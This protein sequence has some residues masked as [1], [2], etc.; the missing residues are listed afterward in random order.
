MMMMMKVNH[1]DFWS[2]QV[3]WLF[4]WL[5]RDIIENKLDD[6]F[7]L[8]NFVQDTIITM[9]MMINMI[10]FAD[11]LLSVR[12]RYGLNVFWNGRKIQRKK[13]F[14]FQS[15]NFIFI[16]FTMKKIV[17]FIRKKFEYPK[18]PEGNSSFF[19]ITRIRIQF[20]L[21]FVSNIST[22]CYSYNSELAVADFIFSDASRHFFSLY[23][24]PTNNQI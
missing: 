20:H 2:T 15:K 14:K 13:K 11:N 9:M 17:Q 16:F 23:I 21:V 4:F 1:N 12:R 19:C 7:L 6:G 3:A 22:F 18:K 10:F 24:S 8:E 5:N